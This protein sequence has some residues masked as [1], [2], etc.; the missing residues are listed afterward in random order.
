MS[1][2][3]Y[4]LTRKKA[5]FEPSIITESSDITKCVDA[6]KKLHPIDRYKWDRKENFFNTEIDGWKYTIEKIYG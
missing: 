2:N 1:S 3:K 4:I 6:V 5:D